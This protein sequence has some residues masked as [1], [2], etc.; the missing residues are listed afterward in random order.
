[1]AKVLLKG[2]KHWPKLHWQ[3]DAV[4]TVDIR[5]PRRQRSWSIYPGEW[6]M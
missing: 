3:Q 2:M 6:K 4:F 5:S 1:M